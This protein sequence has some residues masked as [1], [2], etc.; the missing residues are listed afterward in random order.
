MAALG[1]HQC[2]MIR[3]GYGATRG[4]R[5]RHFAQIILYQ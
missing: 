1:G 5:L 3:G 4:A 2:V